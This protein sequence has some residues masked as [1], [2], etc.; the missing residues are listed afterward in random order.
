MNGGLGIL[1]LVRFARA[2]RLHW[3]WHEWTSPEKAWIGTAT[4][5]DDID[6]LLFAV[7]T[8]ISLGNGKKMSFWHSGWLQGRR[9]H[10]IAPNLF[11]IC[12]HKNR[13]M[14]AA[15]QQNT[16]IRDIRRT[17]GL[18]LDH[19]Q[20]YFTLWELLHDTQLDENQED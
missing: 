20:E 19:I 6:R 16:W 14:V 1:N 2:L 18:T 8:T 5:C 17:R 15:L 10:D 11:A 4:P 13:T 7:C 12:R 9:P 3:L